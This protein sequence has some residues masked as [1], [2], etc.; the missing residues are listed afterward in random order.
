MLGVSLRARRHTAQVLLGLSLWARLDTTQ[1]IIIII[2][3][4]YF[5]ILRY[6]EFTCMYIFYFYFHTLH[7]FVFSIAYI[8]LF[9]LYI[10]YIATTYYTHI[11]Y[12]LSQSYVFIFTHD[13]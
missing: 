9:K 11:F 8:C 7:T 4:L 2:K 3:S 12:F 1:A 6:C 5:T 10:I 13:H